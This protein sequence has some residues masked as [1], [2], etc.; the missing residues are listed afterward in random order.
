MITVDRV[1]GQAEPKSSDMI[2][3]DKDVINLPRKANGDDVPPN[4]TLFIA[5]DTATGYFYSLEDD[6]WYEV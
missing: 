1:G 3:L 4:G 5:M 2:G 6:T